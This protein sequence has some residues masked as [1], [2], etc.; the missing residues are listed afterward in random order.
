M[1]ILIKIIILDFF[2]FPIFGETENENQPRIK[3]IRG[4]SSYCL[5]LINDE[6]SRINNR[7]IIRYI[8]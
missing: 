1:S 3:I 7:Q 5:I 8:R 6:I 2:S 4:G